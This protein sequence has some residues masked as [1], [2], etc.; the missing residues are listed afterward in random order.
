M[1]ENEQEI[2][3][4]RKV[5]STTYRPDSRD[6]SYA[7]HPRN[8]IS[9]F[10]RQA[11]ERLIIELF[12][13]ADINLDDFVSLDVGCGTGGFLRFLSSLETLP[14]HLYGIDLMPY[15][16]QQAK[17]SSPGAI[18]YTLGNAETLPYRDQSF[19]LISQF[20]VFSSIL[21][22]DMRV[23]AAKE[24]CRVLKAGGN[25]L[26]YD[27]KTAPT[28]TTRGIEENEIK[29]LFPSCS[30]LYLKQCHSPY[31]S[32]FA[33]RSHIL[34]ELLELLPGYKTHLIALLQ[35]STAME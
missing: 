20:T 33:K 9:V 25:I 22:T 26:W 34:C 16:I 23:N 14:V 32:R 6:R 3:R 28:S 31:I 19:D 8:P 11:Q 35:K 18:K 21:N 7:W 17:Y 1:T 10:Y 13:Q 24:I 2:D 15:R 5:Y 4:I 29:Q 12:N 30:I 27:M